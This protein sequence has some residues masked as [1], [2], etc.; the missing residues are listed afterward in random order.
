[1]RNASSYTVTDV[2]LSSMVTRVR[3]VESN[4]VEIHQG[5]SLMSCVVLLPHIDSLT[6]ILNLCKMRRNIAA[7]LKTLCEGE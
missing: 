6:L 4:D 2:S 3:N 7:Y 1:M 5:F